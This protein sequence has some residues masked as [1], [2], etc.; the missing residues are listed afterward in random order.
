[1]TTARLYERSRQPLFMQAAG[2]LRLRIEAGVWREG[3]RLP[4][5]DALQAEFGLSRATMRGAL[6][7]LEQEGLIVRRRGHG[8][9]VRPDLEARH[10][11]ALPANWEDLVA[12]LRQVETELIA[13]I[14]SVDASALRGVVAGCA[15]GRFACLRR[16]HRQADEPY[17][18]I[19]IHVRED[20]FEAERENILAG[21]IILLLAER[22]SLALA[23]VAQRVTFS[24]ADGVTAAALG[25]ALC[26]PI[27]EIQRTL[28]DDR[29]S[30]LAH[31][32]VRYPGERVRLDFEFET[33]R[34]N[35]AAAETGR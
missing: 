13:P 5:L 28:I 29:G 3:G 16:V 1:M 7:L 30:V 22:R 21:P 17:C 23:K 15:Q 2:Q 9:F 8:A 27:V 31:T 26:A 12:S 4:A 18:L 10:T 6:E 20:I 35:T 19:D 24:S 25:V 14:A 11:Y 34:A 32:Y 33:R